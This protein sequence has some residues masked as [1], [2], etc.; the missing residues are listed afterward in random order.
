MV[1]VVVG[2]SQGHRG[3]PDIA[4]AIMVG[5]PLLLPVGSAEVES[6]S[7]EVLCHECGRWFSSL[8]GLHAHAAKVHEHGEASM[9]RRFVMS[10]TCPACQVNFR[11][12]EAAT[13]PAV[14][15]C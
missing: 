9:V 2:C 13:V 11:T 1:H 4:T 14:S 7:D 15:S 10:S 5:C 6:E 12:C 8:A 3:S